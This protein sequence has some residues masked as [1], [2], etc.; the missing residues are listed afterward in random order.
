[1]ESKNMTPEGELK[2]ISETFPEAAAPLPESPGPLPEE[3]LER[4]DIREEIADL[5][6]EK[7]TILSRMES[8]HGTMNDRRRLDEINID[9]LNLGRPSE[10]E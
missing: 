6:E 7:R 5:S 9:L 1:M 8:G 2:H 4:R 10:T 3:D